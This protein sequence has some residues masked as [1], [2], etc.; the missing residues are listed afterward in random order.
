MGGVNICGEGIRSYRSQGLAVYPTYLFRECI[1][2]VRV[3]WIGDTSH[4]L[5]ISTQRVVGYKGLN[6]ALDV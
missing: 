1:L 2:G 6:M 4:Q 5:S 3:L